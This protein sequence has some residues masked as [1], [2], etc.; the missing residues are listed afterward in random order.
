MKDCEIGLSS[1]S[2]KDQHFEYVQKTS[3]FVCMMHML[4]IVLLKKRFTGCLLYMT[5][6]IYDF[7]KS[8]LL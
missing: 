8:H 2:K 4:I 6:Y 1:F 5:S 3:A 7:P